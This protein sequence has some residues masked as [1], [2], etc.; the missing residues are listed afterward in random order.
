M[1]LTETGSFGRVLATR[2]SWRLTLPREREWVIGPRASVLAVLNV[3][4]DSFSDGGRFPSP[5][6]A[7]AA[8]LAALADG[9]D[10]I[11]IGGESTR[12]GAV[13]VPVEEQLRRVLP[14][15]EGLRRATDAPL[16][17]DTRSPV[18][19]SAALASGAD[20]VN[21]VAACAD[22]GWIPVLRASS[23]PVILMHMRGTPT[24]MQRR[25]EYPGGVLPEVVRFLAD[26]IQSLA[27]AGISRE[28]VIVDP[29][30]GFAKEA[31]QNVEILDGLGSLAALDRPILFGA[32]R[33]FFLGKILAESSASRGGVARGRDARERD[34]GTVAVN[35]VA[36]LAGASV[37]RVHNVP[38]S[39]DLVDVLDALS[40]V[41]EFGG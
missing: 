32:S 2:R 5:D 11:D 9:A 28:R 10:A 3:T 31:A 40:R 15:V 36:V 35:T 8:G 13:A 22:P 33:K 14:V 20:I 16:S 18:V 21:D 24:D 39:R 37:L 25:T 19:G 34:A 4:P 30:V 6:H 7:V 12:P 1:D 23:C 17:I 29:G 26:R 38:F 27:A 41:P